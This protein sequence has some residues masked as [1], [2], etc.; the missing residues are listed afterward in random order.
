MPRRIKRAAIVSSVL[1]LL[2]AVC[3]VALTYTARSSSTSS[4]ESDKDLPV[5]KIGVTDNDPYVYT[6]IAGDYAG[7]DIDIARE[8]CKRAGIK[9]Q[10]IDISWND[11]DRLLK[12]LDGFGCHQ[13]NEWYQVLGVSRWQQ[14]CC[15]DF[16]FGE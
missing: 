15:G 5:L 8:A 14:D 10:F 11:R 9:P 16:R 2:V 6:D 12:N 1:I 3:A 4:S 13:E 7:I